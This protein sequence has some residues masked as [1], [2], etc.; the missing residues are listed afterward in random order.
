MGSR[1]ISSIMKEKF[2]KQGKKTRISKI[3]ICK[4][5]NEGLGKLEKLREFSSQ[6]TKKKE[7][8]KFCKKIL[9]M[10]LRGKD[11]FF[12]DESIMNINTFVNEK[13]R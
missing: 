6:I 5:L 8:V 1:K 3:T 11:I 13:I 7:R 4:Y 12:T 10:K 9:E 2:E